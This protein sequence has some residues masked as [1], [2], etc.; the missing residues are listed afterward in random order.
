MAT[1]LV[2][3]VPIVALILQYIGTKRDRE[4]DVQDDSQQ[5]TQLFTQLDYISNTLQELRVDIKASD[6][7]REL[8][9]GDIIRLQEFQ[10]RTEYAIE[11]QNKRIAEI[12][13]VQIRKNL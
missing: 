2:A 3:L 5:K 6:R 7:Q 10:R 12:E 11:E 9:N 1:A 4:K 13:K 8:M